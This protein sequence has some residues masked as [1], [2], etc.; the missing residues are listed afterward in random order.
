MKIKE[1]NALMNKYWSIYNTY[2]A[3]TKFCQTQRIYRSG[4]ESIVIYNTSCLDTCLWHGHTCAYLSLWIHLHDYIRCIPSLAAPRSGV[5]IV[6]SVVTEKSITTRDQSVGRTYIVDG[7]S[8]RSTRQPGILTWTL[9]NLTRA[10]F[11]V[12][13]VPY[14]HAL[15]TQRKGIPRL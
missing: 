1:F 6:L 13:P 3:L 15:T 5:P 14:H 9:A 4:H 8:Q 10:T 11:R 7:H 12:K 2:G